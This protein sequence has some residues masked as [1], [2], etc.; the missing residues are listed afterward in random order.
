L[1]GVGGTNGF[2][3][4]FDT[5][6]SLAY[7]YDGQPDGRPAIDTTPAADPNGE[8]YFG[9]NDGS[10]YDVEIPMSGAQMFKA[11]KF[12]PGGAITSSPIVGPCNAGPCL[13]FAS[14]SG[15][16]YFARIGTTRISDL[17]ACI[18]SSL[19][20]TS[21]AGNPRLWARVQVGPGNVWGGSGVFVQGWSFYSP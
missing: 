8:W 15:G 3:Y 4:L 12:G 13:Y 17:R 21:C 5:G 1:I 16:S 11:A 6:L 20:S 2:L 10:V 9:A 19:G 7:S 14:S 18:T